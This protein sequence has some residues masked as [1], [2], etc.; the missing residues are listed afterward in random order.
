MDDVLVAFRAGLSEPA[1]L[2]FGPA[3]ETATR[4]ALQRQIAAARAAWSELT[5]TD[6]AT[7]PSSDG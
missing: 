6:R 2:A 7:R 3:T 4:E 1:L 5:I